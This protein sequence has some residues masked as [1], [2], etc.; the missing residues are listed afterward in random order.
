MLLCKCKKTVP[1]IPQGNDVFSA[2]IRAVLHTADAV[3]PRRRSFDEYIDLSA[4]TDTG[5]SIN[6]DSGSDKNLTDE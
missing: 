4:A 3:P 6:T 5:A 1:V 2:S